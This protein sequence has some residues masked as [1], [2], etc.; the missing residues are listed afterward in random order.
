MGAQGR[1]SLWAGGQN[2][3][4]QL[5]DGTT[6]E[7]NTFVKVIDGGVAD[8]D[9]DIYNTMVIKTD[10]SLW[11]TGHNVKG[12]L[13]DGTTSQR[14][15]FVKVIDFVMDVALG[16]H[17]TMVIK[18]DG[19]LWAAGVNT[20]G[21]H[22]DGTTSQKTKFVQVVDSGVKAVSAGR[23]STGL[24]KQDGSLWAAGYNNVGQLG[25]GT[26]T[27]R[28]KFVKVVDGGVKEVSS[29]VFS[30]V[31]LNDKNE[32]CV[33]GWNNNGQLGTG[34]SH[35]KPT[36]L[37]AKADVIGY[38]CYARPGGCPATGTRCG[39][40]FNQVLA[41]LILQFSAT[42]T[43]AG[44]AIPRATAT[45]SLRR[46]MTHLPSRPIANPVPVEVECD[47]SVLSRTTIDRIYDYQSHY[48][49]DQY[50]DRLHFF[51]TAYY[52]HIRISFL[53]HF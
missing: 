39:P 33:T 37:G 2:K 49:Q 50:H 6:S 53:V 52:H 17:F 46:H 23:H 18:A 27:Q 7:R 51:R 42:K 41:G 13:G 25:D 44:V 12:Q 35:T 40:Q 26:K 4:G 34:E 28:T 29:A 16:E 47:A 11:G 9:A 20:Y 48:Y 24:L 19:S 1:R 14:N 5:G 8:V 43:M 15:S 45:H 30:S 10:G 36:H 22:G 38:K 31:L 32:L 3:F 21:Q